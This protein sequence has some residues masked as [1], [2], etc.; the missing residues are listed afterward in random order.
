MSEGDSSDALAIENWLLRHGPY[1]LKDRHGNV[2][3][4]SVGK[5][6]E[7]F[8]KVFAYLQIE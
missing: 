6:R 8:A 3:F 5:W 2:K 1:S 7:W 4:K